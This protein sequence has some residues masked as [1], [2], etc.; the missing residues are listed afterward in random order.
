MGVGTRDRATVAPAKGE[1]MNYE[2]VDQNR[3]EELKRRLA[4]PTDKVDVV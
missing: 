4:V 1:A 2:I 3:L